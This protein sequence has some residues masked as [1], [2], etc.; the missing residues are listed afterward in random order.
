[1]KKAFSSFIEATDSFLAFVFVVVG[2]LA[3]QL[4]KLINQYPRLDWHHLGMALISPQFVIFSVISL[5][6]TGREEMKGVKDD[7]A[8]AAK[9]SHFFDR[10]ERAFARGFTYTAAGTAGGGT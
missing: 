1:M 10:M 8:R 7:M 3:S 5:M 9:R 4:V 6:N 2:V